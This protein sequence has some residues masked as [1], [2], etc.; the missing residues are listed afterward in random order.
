MTRGGPGEIAGALLE[1]VGQPGTAFPGVAVCSQLTRSVACDLKAVF[2][3][4][5]CMTRVVPD[6]DVSASERRPH[7]GRLPA[8]NSPASQT[9]LILEY[10][11][12]NKIGAI[13]AIRGATGLS[14]RD[15]KDVADRPGSVVTVRSYL[16]AQRLAEDLRAL[17]AHVSLNEPDGGVP[18]EEPEDAEDAEDA[19]PCWTVTLL[20]T[21]QKKILVI[22][23]IRSATGLGLRESK[24]ICDRV[25]STWNPLRSGPEWTDHRATLRERLV[26][27]LLG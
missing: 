16:D 2:Q 13:K 18:L 24:D 6:A 25:P 9:N 27:W 23:E 21:G 10:C 19:R 11:G 14:L 8:G 4:A 12:P 3:D 26:P 5:G 15:A 22:K 7:Y 17:G 1:V 20:D